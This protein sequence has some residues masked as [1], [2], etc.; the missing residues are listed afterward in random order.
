MTL[1]PKQQIQA[2]KEHLAKV[3]ME[4]AGAEHAERTKPPKRGL[5][6]KPKA[7]SKP[8]RT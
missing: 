6:G 2:R 3:A 7:K 1:T 4:R 5:F 8:K